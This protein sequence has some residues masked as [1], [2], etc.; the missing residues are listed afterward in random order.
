M[1]WLNPLN[2]GFVAIVALVVLG[3]ER[4][5]GTLRTVGRYWGEIQRLRTQ[6]ESQMRDVMGDLGIPSSANPTTLAKNYLQGFSATGP[7]ASGS[8]TSSVSSPSI[9]DTRWSSTAITGQREVP[10]RRAWSAPGRL[11]PYAPELEPGFDDPICN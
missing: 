4:L 2:I 10:S 8:S 11:V 9:S 1:Q 7:E 5:P 3:P 6:A